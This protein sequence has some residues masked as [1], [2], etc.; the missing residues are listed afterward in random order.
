MEKAIETMKAIL[1]DGDNTV[2]LTLSDITIAELF[3]FK[4]EQQSA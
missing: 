4:N 2:R 1:S 3:E